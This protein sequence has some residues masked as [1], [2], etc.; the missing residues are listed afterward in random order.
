M[1]RFS[2]LALALAL[3][4]LLVV[5]PPALAKKAKAKSELN[6][7][8]T[9]S[10]DAAAAMA[11]GKAQKMTLPI[12]GDVPQEWKDLGQNEYNFEVHMSQLTVRRGEAWWRVA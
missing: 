12:K 11:E 9:A 1:R 10:A 4:C 8:E 5:C 3:G 7:A 6:L 2:I